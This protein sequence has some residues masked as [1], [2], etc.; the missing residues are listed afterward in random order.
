MDQPWETPFAFSVTN[1]T[2]IHYLYMWYL[3]NN[4]YLCLHFELEF[5]RFI[6]PRVN[7][8]F[9][10]IW[11]EILKND[12]HNGDWK[13]YPITVHPRFGH[14]TTTGCLIAKLNS[15]NDIQAEEIFHPLE[16]H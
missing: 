11:F 6:F 8:Y 7:R 1:W 14:K 5:Y 16:I 12:A 2:V 10:K 15:K 13:K 4:Y 9:Q 3:L